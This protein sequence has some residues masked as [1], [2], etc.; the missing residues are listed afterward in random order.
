MHS[1]L[2]E[3]L[4]IG[5]PLLAGGKDRALLGLRETETLLKLELFRHDNGLYPV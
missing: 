1:E 2:L 5:E 3:Q 4:P